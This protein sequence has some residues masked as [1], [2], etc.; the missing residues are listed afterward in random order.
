MDVVNETFKTGK[1]D[2]DNIRD[3]ANATAKSQI[4]N[5]RMQ[6][7]STITS[8]FAGSGGGGSMG[9]LFD[10]G[11]SYL[12]DSASYALNDMGFGNDAFDALEKSD[13]RSGNIY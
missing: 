9:S 11:V 1:Q 5:G 13:A 6:A 2:V 7:I 12:P 10:T 3:N 8:A 4:S